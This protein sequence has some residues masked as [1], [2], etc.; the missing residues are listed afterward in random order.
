MCRRRSC[1]IDSF[2]L[3]PSHEGEPKPPATPTGYPLF[4]LPPSHEGEHVA[5]LN[6]PAR[7]H[8]FNSRP[9]MRAN[10]SSTISASTW[11]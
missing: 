4:Q 8:H 11:V 6:R 9:R 10:V 1:R 3:P 5:D 7:A 2:Q